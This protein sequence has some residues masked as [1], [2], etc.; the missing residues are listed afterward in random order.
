[1]HFFS[2]HNVWIFRFS[3]PLATRL[4]SSVFGLRF[5]YYVT[6]LCVYMSRWQC[7]GEHLNCASATIANCIPSSSVA[8]VAAVA[9][10]VLLLLLHAN[11]QQNQTRG[12]RAD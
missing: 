12:Q 7:I 6:E 9:V 2:A 10:A 8:D 4:P 11:M 3:W 1:M 5:S